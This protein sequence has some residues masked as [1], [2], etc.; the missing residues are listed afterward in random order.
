MSHKPLLSTAIT[1]AIGLVSESKIIY[2]FS[3]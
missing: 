2:Q 1:I 3:K